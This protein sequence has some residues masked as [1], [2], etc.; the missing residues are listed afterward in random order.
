MPFVF[1]VVHYPSIDQRDA[2]VRGMAGM[3]D[4]MQSQ[5]GCLS[6]D[7][8]LLSED[9]S[10]LVGYSRWESKDAF[11]ATGVTFGPPDEIPEGEVRPRERYFLTDPPIGAISGDG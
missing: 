10:V 2:L 5:P 4:W 9:G 8:P 11:L 1:M 7:P 6:V 3:R